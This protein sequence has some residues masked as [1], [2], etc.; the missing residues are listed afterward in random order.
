LKRVWS[1][2]LLP[3]LLTGFVSLTLPVEI[4]EARTIIVP[5]DYPT[6]QEA[7][8]NA[9]DGDTIYVRN[10][11]YY[12]NVIVHKAVSLVGE[13]RSARAKIPV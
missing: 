6:I 1:G 2:I 5:D 13:D 4:V 12:E 10:E 9:N 11:T 3:I 8:N 7:I